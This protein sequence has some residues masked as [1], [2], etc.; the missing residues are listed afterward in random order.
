M[1]NS[2]KLKKATSI[3]IA[4]GIAFFANEWF[5]QAYSQPTDFGK[6]AMV[7]ITLLVLV[8]V[9]YFNLDEKGHF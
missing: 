1:L 6:W 2:L 9:I 3:T 4:L 7:F 8:A 5:K